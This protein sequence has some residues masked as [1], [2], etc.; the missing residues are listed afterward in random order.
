MYKELSFTYGKD[1]EED[2]I[3][4]Q[5]LRGELDSHHRFQG[6]NVSFLRPLGQ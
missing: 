5:E 4:Q 1:T 6:N 3:W 2:E